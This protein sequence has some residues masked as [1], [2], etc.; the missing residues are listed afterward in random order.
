MGKLSKTGDSG[1]KRLLKEARSQ[2]IFK[3]AVDGIITLD[4]QGLIESF[5]PAAERLFGYSA[6]EAFGKPASILADEEDGRRHDEAL[7]RY[8]RDGG[9]SSILGI[10]RE[11]KGRRKDGEVFP[12]RLSLSEW[13]HEGRPMFTAILHDLS[14]EKRA[15]EALRAS[16]L[17]FRTL[18]ESAPVCIK[19]TDLDGRLLS[20]NPAGLRLLGAPTEAA[21]CG[22]SC[23]QLVADG[24]RER[25]QNYL[26]A[27]AKGHTSRF[28]FSVTT[29][30]GRLRHLVSTFVPIRGPDGAVAR[31]MGQTQD[32]TEQKQAQGQLVQATKMAALGEMAGKIAHEVNNPISI[33]A[34]KARLRLSDP[35]VDLPPKVVK[36]FQKIAEQCD[37][38]G[39]LTRSLID[40]CRPAVS[41]KGPLDVNHPIRKALEIVRDKAKRWG[42]CIETNLAEG[43][44]SV[45]G[46]ATELEQV[47]LNLAINAVD[48]MSSK[49]GGQGGALE[50][51]SSAADGVLVT[52]RDSGIGIEETLRARIFEPFFT[53]KAAKGGTGLGLSVCHGIVEEHDGSIQ[54]ESTLGEGSEFRVKLPGTQRP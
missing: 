38:I 24:D 9:E 16:E 35:E 48:A 19:E 32:V 43:L 23:L 41:P 36:D 46:N 20:M 45:H 49:H 39:L 54:I 52:F 53:T 33:I 8:L 2:A 13:S 51:T 7:A 22:S 28:E 44:P 47:F 10:G 40:Y 29:R 17:R 37:R 31:L 34:A 27:C 6:A 1:D 26:D 11:V 5:N 21:I 12:L 18:V 50:V 25:F 30:D 14:E 4:S 42:V 3:T 15:Q